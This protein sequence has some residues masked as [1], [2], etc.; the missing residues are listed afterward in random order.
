MMHIHRI[1]LFLTISLL[2]AFTAGCS[3]EEVI[4]SKDRG[5]AITLTGEI[6]QVAVSRANDS[7]FCDGDVIGVYVVDY[8]GNNPGKLAATG[9]R[10][11]N[12]RF[13][14]SE[15]TYRWNSDYDIY[16]KDGITHID[17]YGYY[18]Y[19]NPSNVDAFPF[20]VQKDQSKAAE[21][22]LL[23]GYEASDFLWGKATDVAPTAS[24]VRLS[25]KHRMANVR[26][27]LVEGTGF[28]SGEWSGLEKQALVTNT[29]RNSVVNLVDGT[30]T[31]VGDVAVTGTIPSKVNDEFRAIV[32]PQT[33]AAAKSLFSITVGGVAYQFTKQEAFT[34]VSGKMH[35]FSI[36][37]NKKTTTGDFEFAVISESI[38]AWENDLVSHDAT[39]REYIVVD[40]PEAGTLK[41]CIA[42]IGKDY[43]RLQNLKITGQINANDF[44]FMRDEMTVLRSLNLK[45]VVIKECESVNEEADKI[46]HHAFNMN[47]SLFN[48]VFPDQLKA[49]GNDAFARSNLSGSII[50]PEGVITIGSY[51]F[52]ECAKLNG[53]LVL[54]TTL[55]TIEMC[56]FFECTFVCELKLPANLRSIGE[57]A[58]RDC[59]GLHG[60]LIFPEGLEEIGDG[61][62]SGCRSLTGSLIIP[63]KMKEIPD[64]AFSRTGLNGNLIL[65]DGVVSIGK[66]AFALTPMRGEL[67]F[68]QSLIIIDARAFED[69]DFSGELKFPRKLHIIGAGAFS[70]NWRLAGAIDI[71][72]GVSSIGA[73]AF[74]GCRNLEGVAFPDG[75]ESIQQYAF[76]GCSGI[77]SIVCKGSMPPYVE[78]TAFDGVS[79]DNFV[80]EVPEVSVQQYQTA[81]GW[82]EFK[83]ITA[84]HELVCRPSVVS[85]INTR[86]T[87]SLVLNAEGDWEVE[88]KPS[89]CTLSAMSGSRKTELIL[90]IDAMAHGGENRTGDI[91][92]KLKGK[93]YTTRCAVSQYDYE[94]DEDKI[95]TL[96]SASKGKG[97]NLV[98]LGDGYGAEDISTGK[99]LQDMRDQ[100][101]HFFSVEPYFT[102]RSFFNV[103]TGIA[104]SSESGIGT[105][106]TIRDTKFQTIFNND[107]NLKADYEAIF[108]YA[109]RTPTINQANLNQSLI[110]VTPNTSE[111][112]GVCQ[113]WGDGS[114]IAFCPKSTYAY[115]YDTRGV[116]QH[117]ACGHGFGKLGDEH[118]NFN[119]FI[120][121]IY[122]SIL[123]E[124]QTLGW[125]QNLSLSG[126]IHEV[127]WS[128]LIMHERYSDAVDVFEGGFLF[129]RGVYRSEK[130][131]CMNNNVPYFNT[132]SREIIVKRIMGYAGEQF[133]FEK[134]VANDKMDPGS[135]TR[136]SVSGWRSNPYGR[137]NFPQLH[138]GSP[139]TR[140]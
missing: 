8:A 70:N 62:F 60:E 61:A 21:T 113:M 1:Y 23:G 87:R 45:E 52:L 48:I 13:A 96:Q 39:A 29:K 47:K 18:P 89:W 123:R 129:S 83:R 49:I 104:L 106:N 116:L 50:I 10:A 136:S 66:S 54:P 9:N 41:E 32:V 126:K 95:I 107:V 120:N 137:Q 124:Q 121:C 37:V 91:V 102:Y 90:T 69:C 68:P 134:F 80:V 4:P 38:T 28:A 119:G 94:Y 55:E 53:T 105:V 122:E 139:V 20:E 127:P 77:N 97:V 82:S 59:N 98:F 42:K 112:G 117:E 140:K 114:A 2:L 64:N 43:K 88:S 133:T 110:I 16:W 131:S 138:P 71:P 15:T 67:N 74:S 33:V 108:N 103:Y 84:Y 35:N 36:A 3:D 12:A 130:N 75:L 76:S 115:P 46:P 100:V 11:S 132:I 44:Y 31:A 101:E 125:S 111:Y 118:V 14:F 63:S 19:A 99:Y 135:D 92:F 25:F 78:S 40:V 73:N 5:K 26:V 128:H 57:T 6:D 65:H 85:A 22:G 109:L 93:D 27:T 51:A 72:E 79:K 7:G 17:V 86:Y 30:V 58:F 56:G 24:V 81:K 34:Y